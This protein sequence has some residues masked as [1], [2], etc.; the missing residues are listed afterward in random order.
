[1]KHKNA[2]LAASAVVVGLALAAWWFQRP[3][4][5][6]E[7]FAG[8]LNHERY[9]EAARMLRAPS[10][11]VV[12]PDGGPT[13]VDEAGRSTSV[14]AAQLPFAAGGHAA[15]EYAGDFRMTALGPSTNG[16]LHSPAVTLHLAVDGGAVRIVGVDS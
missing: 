5:T 8:H 14:P 3:L 12:A 15:P 16:V 11:L 10:S 6:T 2:L 7:A 13:L 1:M 4:R 9:E